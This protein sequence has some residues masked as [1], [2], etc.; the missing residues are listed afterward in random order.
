MRIVH[1]HDNDRSIYDTAAMVALTGRRAGAVRVLAQSARDGQGYD[2]DR[3]VPLL[4]AHPQDPVLLSARDIERHTGIPAG[5]VYSWAA[6]G[7]IKCRDHDERGM[8]LYHVG[9]LPEWSPR[10]RRAGAAYD[11]VVLGM[12]E[13]QQDGAA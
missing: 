10:P 13:A 5:T 11:A 8:P 4:A 2:V 12:G 6:R 1:D 9:D 3:A 7:E